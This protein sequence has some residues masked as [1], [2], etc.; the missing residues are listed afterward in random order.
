MKDYTINNFSDVLHI[1]KIFNDIPKQFRMMVSQNVQ[2]TLI[3]LD[4]FTDVRED[5]QILNYPHT[6]FIV[7]RVNPNENKFEE[8]RPMLNEDDVE[9]YNMRVY[10]TI[11]LK[12]DSVTNYNEII[13]T[14]SLLNNEAD[15]LYT[16]YFREHDDYI[17]LVKL[18]VNKILTFAKYSI[19]DDIV[20]SCMDDI[21]FII[22]TG[23]L[24]D[25]HVQRL[26]LPIIR[27]IDMKLFNM[28]D[29][30]KK[31]IIRLF[32]SQISLV[33]IRHDMFFKTGTTKYL[34]TYLKIKKH[35][36]EEV[37]VSL[38]IDSDYDVSNFTGKI[39]KDTYN[40]IENNQTLIKEGLSIP[41][42]I[43]LFRLNK[44]G[45]DTI[46]NFNYDGKSLPIYVKED[47][48]Y[49]IFKSDKNTFTFVNNDGVDYHK[50]KVEF[51]GRKH[52]DTNSINTILESTII[53]TNMMNRF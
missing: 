20:K 30:N 2:N 43:D 4:T 36:Y 1:I 28:N 46:V 13:T 50:H 25:N 32:N 37:L 53:N 39:S 15:A 14:C 40:I 5:N 7:N 21:E 23:I 35:E 8:L 51:N 12:L 22:A 38:P 31:R 34:I 47:S 27:L 19:S 49:V 52:L 24:S 18:S 42:S 10:D 11:S 48:Q 6:R 29:E 45:F 44:N 26:M 33:K 16:E 41:D 9:S 3:K 17:S